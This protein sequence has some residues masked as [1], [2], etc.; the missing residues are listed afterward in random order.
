MY[1]RINYII[2]TEEYNQVMTKSEMVCICAF[3]CMSGWVRE[4]GDAV[5]CQK[6]I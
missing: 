4:Y 3:V 5:L 2:P 6:R 1:V